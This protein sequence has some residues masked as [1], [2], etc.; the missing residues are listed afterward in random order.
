MLEKNYRSVINAKGQEE[1]YY[2]P[3]PYAKNQVSSPVFKKALALR[4]YQKNSLIEIQKAKKEGINVLM[5]KVPTGGGKTFIASNIVKSA[6]SRDMRTL[7]V[8]DRIE[9]IGQ[10]SERFDDDG[11]DHSIIQASNPRLDERKTIQI[12]SAQTI[13]RW[14]MS[15][16]GD[17]KVIII[18]EAH[19]FYKVHAQLIKHFPDALIL[20]LSATPYTRGLGKYYKK[21]I[22]VTNVKELIADGF[23]VQPVVYAPSA[24]DLEAIT[25]TAGDFNNEELAKAT[26]QPKLVGDIVDHWHKLAFNKP[27]ICFAVNIEHSKAIV[28][29]F[30]LR[31]VVAEH[32]DAYTES[33]DR[34]AIIKKFKAGEIKVLS[35]VDVLS[36]GFDYP[37]AEVAILARPTKSLSLYIQQ[38]GRV[39]RIADGKDTC[40]ILDH[41][42][43]TERMGFLTD[44]FDFELDMGEKGKSAPA[45][46]K[47][48]LEPVPKACPSCA[49]VKTTFICPNCNFQFAPKD[50]EVHEG[51]L[52]MITPE[53][54]KKAT[55][56]V[57]EELSMKPEELMG[58]L[59]RLCV[60]KGWKSGRAFFMF[61]D[62]A[63]RKPTW[64]ESNSKELEPTT[65]LLGYIKHLNIKKAKSKF[66]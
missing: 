53:T 29:A 21:L 64:K 55:K 60:N 39:L 11:I 3:A 63:N 48:K 50:V 7:F 61:Q 57:N 16:L 30:N 41:A 27:T 28:E 20:G 2:P 47:E 26:N 8:C 19:T 42:G 49:F 56:S 65:Q 35:S 18:D 33:D 51:N 25:T 6:L 10:T 23:L 44:D 22:E 62:I 46:K 15:E 17:V 45:K 43:N 36:K 24:P 58:Q 1:R 5:L 40:L 13:T 14:K 38:G 12:C 4:P 66:H 37:G 52:V 31:G 34:K 9:L 59:K 54:S 32:I